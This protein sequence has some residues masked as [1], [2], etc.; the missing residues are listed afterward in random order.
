M[1]SKIQTITYSLFKILLLMNSNSIIY[2]FEFDFYFS[3]S[4][5]NS[6]KKTEFFEFAAWD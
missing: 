3:N 4:C 5:L 1:K 6:A 2:I